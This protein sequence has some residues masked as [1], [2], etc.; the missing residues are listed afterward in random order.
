MWRGL[1]GDVHKPGCC[2][3]SCCWKTEGPSWLDAR[4]LR[5]CLVSRWFYFRHPAWPW[6]ALSRRLPVVPFWGDSWPGRTWA[7][8]AFCIWRSRA[9]WGGSLGQLSSPRS[10]GEELGPAVW[11]WP[12]SIPWLP[13][14]VSW[15]LRKPTAAA[16]APV[17]CYS[18][19]Q[20]HSTEVKLRLRE[21][22][23]LPRVTQLVSKENSA[24]GL[25]H[26][27]VW[28]PW[29]HICSILQRPH[30]EISVSDPKAHAFPSKPVDYFPIFSVFQ[31]I[32][33]PICPLSSL[34]LLNPR[35][36]W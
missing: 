27:Q 28:W 6:Q 31:I 12:E 34:F 9:V 23:W 30:L 32:K 11:A 4:G 15:G 20:E 21:V 18:V 5:R 17:L 3:S 26:C 13:S 25:E 7:S 24:T 35:V 36:L 22:R 29:Y 8:C 33:I 16:R 1:S 2:F 19:A 14:S 10:Q